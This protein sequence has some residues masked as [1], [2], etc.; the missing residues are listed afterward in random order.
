MFDFP[1]SV[2]KETEYELL[3]VDPE[4]TS[5]EINEAKAELSRKLRA[6][7]AAAQRK[8]EAVY[9]SLPELRTTEKRVENLRAGDRDADPNE[10]GAELK[11]LAQLEQKALGIDS[12]FREHR[13]KVFELQRQIEAVNR[14]SLHSAEDREEYDRQHP[15]L[16]L[17]KFPECTL[18]EFATNRRLALALVRRDLIRFFVEKGEE[19]FHPSDLTREDFSRDFAHNPILDGTEP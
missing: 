8:L 10:L 11:K 19:V 2:S 17:I 18:D 13:E 5:R 3:G 16:G 12:G 14:V 6:D 15:P 1:L 7:Q 4:A 9:A